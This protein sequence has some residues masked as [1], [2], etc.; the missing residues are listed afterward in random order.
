VF[1]PRTPLIRNEA[2]VGRGTQLAFAPFALMMLLPMAGMAIF[3]EP[4]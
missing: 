3:L 4:A 2:G 1:H